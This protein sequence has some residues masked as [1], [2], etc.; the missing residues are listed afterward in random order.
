[1]LT[2]FKGRT[3]EMN[4][5]V[6]CFWNIHDNVFSLQ[7]R[8]EERGKKRNLVCSHGNAIVLTDVKF[9]VNERLRQQVLRE[10]Q[11]NIHAYV[12]GVYKGIAKPFQFGK[13]KN[14]MREAYYNPYKVDSFIDK[15]TGEKLESAELVLLIDKKVYYK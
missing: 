1:M 6:N 14:G 7:S 13:N 5:K 4:Q 15:D 10:Q 11:K 9:S 3:V 12:K 8:I 2:S